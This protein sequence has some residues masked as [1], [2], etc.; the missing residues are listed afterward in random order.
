MSREHDALA[1][2]VDAIDRKLDA[3][4]SNYEIHRVTESE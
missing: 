3:H 1:Q 4:I 2:K